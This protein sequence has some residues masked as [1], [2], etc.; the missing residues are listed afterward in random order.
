MSDADYI[1][2]HYITNEGRIQKRPFSDPDPEK[3]PELFK[4]D[5][6]KD[7]TLAMVRW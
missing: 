6:E 1:L 3:D 2:Y 7:R 4:E 5:P